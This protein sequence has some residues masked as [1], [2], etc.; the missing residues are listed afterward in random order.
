MR[1]LNL[2]SSSSDAYLNELKKNKHLDGIEVDI[3]NC[4]LLSRY[5]ADINHCEKCKG[6]GECQNE[7]KGYKSKISQCGTFTNLIKVPCGFMSDELKKEEIQSKFKTLFLPAQ[8]REAS[9]DDYR[10]DTIERQKIYRYMT[11]F[12][13]SF[14]RG[15]LTKGL[16]ICGNFQIG[17]TYSLACA[18]NLFAKSGID[19]LLIYFPDLI[20]ELKSLLGKTDEFENRINMLKSVDVLMLDD[21]GAEMPSAWVRD[22]ILCPILNYRA[23]ERLPVFFTT[24]YTIEGLRE[25]YMRSDGSA[26]S[27]DRLMSRIKTLST[28]VEFK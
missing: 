9:F 5:L 6:L 17:K 13:T 20:R 24:N 8:I 10:L 19:S 18:A 26:N 4:N 27:A 2:D 28:F 7:P 3:N 1:K 22:E 11:N 12:S 23:Q 25:F 14:K 21:I 16:F 15:T